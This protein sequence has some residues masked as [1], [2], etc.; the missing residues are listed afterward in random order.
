VE[1]AGPGI[2]AGERD[3]VF[4]RFYR[5]PHARP[6][7]TGLGL[8]I[9]REVVLRHHGEVSL[10]TAPGGQGL[11]VRVTLPSAEALAEAD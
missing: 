1:D 10:H 8:A 5:A 4:A 6:G 9:V 3:K 2:P 11:L 7:G